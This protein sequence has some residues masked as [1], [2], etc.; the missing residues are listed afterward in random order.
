M[1]TLKSAKMI[2]AAMLLFILIGTMSYLAVMLAFGFD[3]FYYFR[4]RANQAELYS[5]NFWSFWAALALYQ[6]L[7]LLGFSY[8]F[9]RL[10][11]ASGFSESEAGDRSI[12]KYVMLTGLCL[13]T[14]L[15]ILLRPDTGFYNNPK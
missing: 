4:K 15:L 12:I 2:F 11:P 13:G 6:T 7:N 14:L 5:A 8:G 9:D 3:I 1:E 10:F